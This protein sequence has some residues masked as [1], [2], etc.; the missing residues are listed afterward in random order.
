MAKFTYKLTYFDKVK[1]K[2]V[3]QEITADSCVEARSKAK[4]ILE[5]KTYTDAHFTQ[6]LIDNLE[7]II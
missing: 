6:R 5:G 3:S 7:G 1:N 4:E 2:D